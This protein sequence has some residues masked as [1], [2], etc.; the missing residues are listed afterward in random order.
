MTRGRVRLTGTRRV[1][2]AFLPEEVQAAVGPA[3]RGGQRGPVEQ[4]GGCARGLTS[5]S[6]CS[7]SR[8]GGMALNL[9]QPLRVSRA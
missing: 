5:G 9:N 7:G 1:K 6:R 8:G 4:L 3:G 2:R